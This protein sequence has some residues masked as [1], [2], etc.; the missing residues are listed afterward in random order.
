M[1][2]T[3]RGSFWAKA[4]SRKS[5]YKRNSRHRKLLFRLPAHQRAA[6]EGAAVEPARRRAFRASLF[7]RQSRG[8]QS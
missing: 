8:L 3:A 6:V 5:E 4:H 7:R 1:S 2:A